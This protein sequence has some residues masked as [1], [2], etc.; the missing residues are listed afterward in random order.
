M[1]SVIWEEGKKDD[2][3]LSH[4]VMERAQTEAWKACVVGV[5]LV[6]TETWD[7]L[8]KMLTVQF[9]KQHFARSL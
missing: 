5:C 8:T 3:L 7:K 4:P 1:R 2:W 9:S 6:W